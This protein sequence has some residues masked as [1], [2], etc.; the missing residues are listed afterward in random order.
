M[1]TSQESSLDL[2]GR[3]AYL[4][5]THRTVTPARTLERVRP[6]LEEMG[7]TRVANVT[8]LDRIGIPVVAVVRPNSRSVSVAQGKGLDLDAA[9]ASG[10]MESIESWHAERISLPLLLGC[11]SDL[12][13]QYELVDV[14]GLPRPGGSRYESGLPILWI[15]GV[16]LYSQNAKLLPYEIVHTNY[17]AP[18][19]SGSGCFFQNS[20]GL[21]SGN[22][23]GEAVVHGICEV[24]ERDAI[25]VWHG[26]FRYGD[27]GIPLDLGSVDDPACER[28]LRRLAAADMQV[29]VWDITGDVGVAAFYCVLLDQRERSNHFGVGAGCHL[30]REVALLR[31]LT[32]A[33]Q[34]RTTYI[35]GARDD[36][37][38]QEYDSSTMAARI[39]GLRDLVA[40]RTVVKRDFAE[41]P[42]F[43]NTTVQEDIDQVLVRL[44]AV[45]IG[46]VV[47]VDLTKPGYSIPV[48]RVVIPGLEA[49][50]DEPGYA[51]GR[52]AQSPRSVT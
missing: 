27:Y 4:C 26:R 51:P 2:T 13:T 17:S 16:D 32:E 30:S 10:V 25:S 19:P 44:Q 35:A 43:V 22:H 7:I 38:R 5:G 3:K 46:E 33:V 11:E 36:L 12:G 18:A 34:V 45:G 40:S 39:A 31:A 15:K 9:R 23:L 52:R 24:V 47:V 6:F 37:S 20:N 42:D 50:H 14:G 48:V 28:V 1:L 8:G 49:P 29:A 21:A 41:V